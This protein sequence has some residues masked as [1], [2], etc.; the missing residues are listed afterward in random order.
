MSDI[1]L[2]GP[3]TA[4][5]W[6]SYDQKTFWVAVLNEMDVIRTLKKMEA[7]RILSAMAFMAYMERVL[8]KIYP[9]VQLACDKFGMSKKMFKKHAILG[10]VEIAAGWGLRIPRH[11]LL[12]LGNR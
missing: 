11:K 8:D 6:R 7:H 5:Q 9:D 3:N 2:P 1:V 12:R 4:Q 10:A